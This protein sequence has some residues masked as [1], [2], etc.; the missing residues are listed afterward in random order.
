MRSLVYIVVHVIHVIH[1]MT[2]AISPVHINRQEPRARIIRPTKE[3]LSIT[4]ELFRSFERL[5]CMLAGAR[6]DDLEDT[7]RNRHLSSYL[8][9]T[10]G[11][12]RFNLQGRH[13]A[14]A[15]VAAPF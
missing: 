15:A 11:T 9:S 8:Y 4:G 2:S 1:V 6:C 5:H 3:V 7:A 10:R 14:A 13:R 12:K